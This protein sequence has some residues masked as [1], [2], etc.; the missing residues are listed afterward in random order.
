MTGLTYSDRDEERAD[1]RQQ[2]QLLAALDAAP[3]QLRRDECGSWIIAGRR[4]AVHTWGDGKTWL[5]Y[6]RCRSAQHW[7]FTKR[8]LAFMT[9]TQDG[10]DEGCLRL[11][12]LPTSQEGVVIRD[13]TGLRKR[14]DYEPD[15]LERK[16]ASMAK[17]G[18]ARETAR[19]SMAGVGMPDEVNERFAPEGG[20]AV[21]GEE[22]LGVSLIA[23][24]VNGRFRA[25]RAAT[26]PGTV[27]TPTRP[28]RAKK[29]PLSRRL[30]PLK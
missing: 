28:V 2:Q 30:T 7:T 22:I 16:R 8:R 11:D 18:L 9:V 17:A 15:A 21:E 12:R 10:D 23:A 29:R 6:V 19:A 1:R 27:L 4:G 13:V 20:L 14:V 3:A 25:D 26:A 24:G 5:A